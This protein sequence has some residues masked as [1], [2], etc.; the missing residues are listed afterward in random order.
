MMSIKEKRNSEIF[1]RPRFSIDLEENSKVIVQRIKSQ[2]SKDDCQF[3]SKISEN[4]I[5]ID[6]LEN[7]N[8]YWSPQLHFEVI[9]VDE[10]SSI[11]KGLF[12]P[13]PQVW[14]LFIFIHFIIGISFLVFC[15]QLYSRISLNE[16]VFFPI[17]MMIVL[18]LVWVLLYFL[19][20]IGKSTGK[21][22][23]RELHD[24]LINIINN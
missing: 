3:R 5:F 12:G 21:N 19:G 9:K 8:H 22:Q 16:S 4:H 11:I 18:A 2:L 17:I 14:T 1:L 15:I 10:K 24:F 23:M 7:K 6:I 13:K 20:K